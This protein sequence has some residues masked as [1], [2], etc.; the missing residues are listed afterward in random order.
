[1][2]KFM[3]IGATVICAVVLTGCGAKQTKQTK[4]KSAAQQSSLIA[5][6]KHSTDT[7]AQRTAL[8]E[9][10]LYSDQMH[11]SE[12]QIYS[13]LT[14][15]KQDNLSASA[16]KWALS[17]LSKKTWDQN[18]LKKAQAYKKETKL[19]KQDIFN[20]LISPAGDA[21]KPAQAQYAVNHLKVT[22]DIKYTK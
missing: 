8:S 21:F 6:S 18:A 9:A 22:T 14:S 10:S 17:K 3:T 7:N 5:A 16:S 20:Q 15:K 13:K 19:T 4:A 11:M 1:M 12:S 2:K